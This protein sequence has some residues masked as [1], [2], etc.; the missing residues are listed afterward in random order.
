MDISSQGW[1]NFWWIYIVISAVMVVVTS[2]WLLIGGII[3][4]RA[5]FRRLDAL[6][7]DDRDAGMVLDE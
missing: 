4:L 5:M 3:D 6:K 2:I 1:A 7:R